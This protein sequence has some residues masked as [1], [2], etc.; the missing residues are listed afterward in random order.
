MITECSK[1]D[2]HKIFELTK[3]L[4]N[5]VPFCKPDIGCFVKSWASMIDSGRG[6]IFN[7]KENDCID[8]FISGLIAPEMN[9]GVLMA[10]ESLWYLEPEKRKTGIGKKLLEHFEK[11][12]KSK[13]AKYICTAKPYRKASINGYTSIE[14]F[15]VKEI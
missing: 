11:W 8:G 5:E 9:S 3:K 12:A 13:N 7:S 4:E 1:N 6:V 2:L 15:F 14:T 10:V